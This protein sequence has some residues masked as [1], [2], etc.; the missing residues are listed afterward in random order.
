MRAWKW[1]LRIVKSERGNSESALVLIPLMTLFLI[2]MQV[3]VAVHARNMEKISVQSDAS[4]RALTGDFRE[5][6][7][8]IHIADS[9]TRGGLD[10][11]VTHK[12]SRLP[13][14]FRSERSTNVDGIAVV[15]N[16]R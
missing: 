9:G 6:D 14:L 1:I 10:L 15:E 12:A 16:Q 13:E 7:E 2:A 5:G 4:Q 11:L 3:S 8:F